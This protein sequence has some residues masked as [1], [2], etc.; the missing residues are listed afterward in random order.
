[1]GE[2]LVAG[3][4]VLDEVEAVGAEG[5]GDPDGEG[6]GDEEVGDVADD[7]QVHDSAPFYTRRVELNMF[8]FCRNATSGS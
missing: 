7:C 4:D 5:A 2:L 1:M 6:D 8:N 3:E